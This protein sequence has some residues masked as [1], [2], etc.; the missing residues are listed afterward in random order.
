MH[1]LTARLPLGGHI[2]YKCNSAV[3]PKWSFHNHSKLP[4]NVKINQMGHLH[5]TGITEKNKGVYICQGINVEDG[6]QFL[7]GASLI[8]SCEFD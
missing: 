2:R 6:A 1:P 5:I 3:L 8:V 7:S 4:S